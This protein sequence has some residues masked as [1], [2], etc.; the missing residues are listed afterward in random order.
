MQSVFNS[1]GNEKTLK[2]FQQ[3]H[4]QI[5]ASGSL[6]GPVGIEPGGRKRSVLEDTTDHF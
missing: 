3:V 2:A 1:V 5:Y 6:V 4:E